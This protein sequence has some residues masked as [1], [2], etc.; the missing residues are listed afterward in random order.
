MIRNAVVVGGAR[1]GAFRGDHTALSGLDTSTVFFT[2][3]A[4]LCFYSRGPGTYRVQEPL[5]VQVRAKLVASIM[6]QAGVSHLGP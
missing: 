6:A 2:V 3:M 5:P 4:A 1:G